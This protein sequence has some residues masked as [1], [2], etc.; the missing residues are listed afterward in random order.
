MEIRGD[1]I[2]FKSDDAYA[3]LRGYG[4]KARLL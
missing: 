2:Y 1:T 4:R 3:T